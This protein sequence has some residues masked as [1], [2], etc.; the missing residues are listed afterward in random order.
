MLVARFLVLRL[1]RKARRTSATPPDSVFGDA[2]HFPQSEQTRVPGTRFNRALS[3]CED[4]AQTQLTMV[5]LEGKV[6]CITGAASGIAFAVARLAAQSGARLAICDN[7]KEQLD[8]AVSTLRSATDTEVVGTVVDVTSDE[9]VRRWIDATVEHFG[10]LDGAANFAGVERKHGAFTPIADLSN[11]EWDWVLS[12]NLTGLMY[13]LRAQL[14]VMGSGSSIVNASSIAGLQGKAG[15]APY[16]VSKHGVVGLSR[17][18]AKENGSRGIR[19][20]AVAP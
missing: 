17:T 14:K 1:G 3:R 13:C 2:P 4:A 18:A 15:L 6:I 9:Q 19:V 10:R 11:E 12:V 8:Q 7:Q 16:S 5:N 20:N